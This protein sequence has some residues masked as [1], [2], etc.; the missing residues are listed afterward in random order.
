MIY[1]E[2]DQF[3]AHALEWDIPAYAKTEEAAKNEL[4]GLLDNQLGFAAFMGKLEM[5]L[6]PAPKEFF[7]RWEEAHSAWLRGE[8]VADTPLSLDEKASIW[9]YSDEDLRKLRTA[10]KRDFSKMENTAVA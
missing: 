8:T 7:D 10:R 4:E 5:V 9:V 2:G 3:V 1:K 6:F